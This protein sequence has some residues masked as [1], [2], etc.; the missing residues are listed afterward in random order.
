MRQQELLVPEAIATTLATVTL[1]A[2]P[3]TVTLIPLSVV[4]RPVLVSLGCACTRR[5]QWVYRVGRAGNV[6]VMATVVCS[7]WRFARPMPSAAPMS[8]LTP[9][10]QMVGVPAFRPGSGGAR[11]TRTAAVAIA[12]NRLCVARPR[13]VAE[14]NAN[15]NRRLSP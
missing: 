1:I 4:P 14:S 8:V 6:I 10:P 13:A 7:T 3:Q 11:R 12:G 5:V 2:I 9:L 15:C